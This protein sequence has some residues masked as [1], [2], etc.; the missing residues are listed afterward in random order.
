[1]GRNDDDGYEEMLRI[2]DPYRGQNYETEEGVAPEAF[3]GDDAARLAETEYGALGGGSVEEFGAK[4][5]DE[6]RHKR[7]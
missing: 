3:N 1:M 7:S 2:E 6:P 5:R 4:H